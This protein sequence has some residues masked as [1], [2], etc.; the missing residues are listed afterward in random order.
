MPQ[1]EC[2]GTFGTC[3]S[4]GLIHH[5][6][7]PNMQR[8]CCCCCCSFDHLSVV[9]G[10]HEILIEALSNRIA[11]LSSHWSIASTLCLSANTMR[12]N[13]FLL[14]NWSSESNYN[15]LYLSMWF[16]QRII[17]L[18]PPYG[19]CGSVSALRRN[20]SA[21]HLHELSKHIKNMVWREIIVVAMA[22]KIYWIRDTENA[23]EHAPSHVFCWQTA[24]THA[25]RARKSLRFQYVIF[26]LTKWKRCHGET[27]ARVL[28]IVFGTKLSPHHTRRCL[29]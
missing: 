28:C 10:T 8:S 18:K 12:C 20:Y 1:Y 9:H 19:P 26:G 23:I 27:M 14:A 6:I 16:E 13:I 17:R 3:K 7:T 4:A 22:H 5:Q 11:H 24:Q 25:G 29:M 21:R 15:Q 2:S